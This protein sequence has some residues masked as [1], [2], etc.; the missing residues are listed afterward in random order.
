[1]F[2]YH[3]SRCDLGEMIRDS[4]TQNVM[5]DGATPVIDIKYIT[6]RFKKGGKMEGNIE[7]IYNLFLSRLENGNDIQ[8]IM[9]LV[10]IT[11]MLQV[12]NFTDAKIFSEEFLTF[13][14]SKISADFVHPSIRKFSLLLLK[15]MMISNRV[16]SI[17]LF[18]QFEWQYLISLLP[19]IT[20]SKV[21]KTCIEMNESFRNVLVE[22]N[23]HLTIL[24][25]I[26]NH[27]DTTCQNFKTYHEKSYMTI[28]LT[29][30]PYVTFSTDAKIEFLSNVKRNIISQ[31]ASQTYAQ[32]KYI[33]FLMRSDDIEFIHLSISN[34]LI[35]N[36]LK[37]FKTPSFT[38]IRHDVILYFQKIASASI[39]FANYFCQEN[40]TEHMIRLLSTDYHYIDALDF[41]LILCQSSSD[42]C[43]KMMNDSILNSLFADFSFLKYKE[44]N[45]T[46]K[47]YCLILLNYTN[48]PFVSKF[49]AIL[50]DLLDHLSLCLESEVE[51]RILAL[52]LLRKIISTENIP[53]NLEF[54]NHVKEFV[55]SVNFQE[56]LETISNDECDEQSQN[57]IDLLID[58]IEHINL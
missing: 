47:L 2:S 22:N 49:T 39:E 13:L 41:L 14:W 43:M 7:Q 44:M 35:F 56:L 34:Y 38:N 24:N 36:M 28:L 1:M 48:A 20:A 40:L 32:K 57:E 52:Q 27:S 55:L 6:P 5:K 16:T 54:V 8:V 31:R 26:S 15:Q 9:A 50:S 46:A 51:I 18:E 4:P 37:F 33:K 12:E 3:I 42:N 29:L 53:Q 19:D 58:A 11:N 23:F 10:S 25:L 45:A 30:Q 17:V 21:L